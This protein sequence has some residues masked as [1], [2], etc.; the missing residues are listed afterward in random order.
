MEIPDVSHWASTAKASVP[1][2]LFPGPKRATP[3]P[4]YG[5]L[6]NLQRLYNP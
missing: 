4:F 6:N 2:L 3:I 5:L 1:K